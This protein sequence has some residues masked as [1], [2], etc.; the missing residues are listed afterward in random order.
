LIFNTNL[1][2]WQKDPD[3]S[4]DFAFVPL[5]VR[6]AAKQTDQFTIEIEA[7]AVIKFT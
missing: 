3:Q 2:Q 1:K 7:V 4:K 5:K 6:T